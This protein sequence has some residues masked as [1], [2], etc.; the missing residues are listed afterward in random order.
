MVPRAAGVGGVVLI[1]PLFNSRSQVAPGSSSSLST[2]RSQSLHYLSLRYLESLRSSDFAL[3]APEE[4]GAQ[5][6][7]CVTGLAGD[8]LSAQ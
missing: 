8:Q 5:L 2:P 4:G 3:T 7:S 6:V 1:L